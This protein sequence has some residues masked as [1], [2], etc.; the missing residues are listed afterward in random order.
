MA[1]CRSLVAGF[2]S[3]ASL[4]SDF[5]VTDSFDTVFSDEEVVSVEAPAVYSAMPVA[6][7]NAG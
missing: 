3:V 1:V 2:G 6:L 4:V 5:A 7:R